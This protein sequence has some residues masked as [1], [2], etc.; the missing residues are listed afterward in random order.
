MTYNRPGQ[1]TH[2]VNDS[3]GILAHNQP[4]KL[5]NFV[6]VLVKQKT[7]KWSDGLAP[8]TQIQTGEKCWMITKGIVQI[9]TSQS[10][11]SGIAAAAK[12]A[13]IYIDG[14]NNLTTT[15]TSNTKFGRVIEVIG[16]GRTVPTNRIRI[17]LDAKDSF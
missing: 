1:G 17:S 16:D 12:G 9:D 3:G 6:G 15:A 10:Y 7:T 5:Q 13:A 2:V 11:A 8:V 14:S 4:A